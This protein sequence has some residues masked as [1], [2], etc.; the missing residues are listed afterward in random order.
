M[1]KK[2]ISSESSDYSDDEET[3]PTT[4]GQDIE[5]GR[6]RKSSD[7][8]E[9]KELVPLKKTKVTTVTSD[10]DETDGLTVDVLEI[11]SLLVK[12]INL[13]DDPQECLN[14]FY[15]YVLTLKKNIKL[16]VYKL[17]SR[18]KG[19]WEKSPQTTS[20]ISCVSNI[21][22][23]IGHTLCSSKTNT[24]N[25]LKTLQIA[26]DFFANKIKETDSSS[27]SL[28]NQKQTQSTS[29][30]SIPA[31]DEMDGVDV[32]SEHTSL[33][34]LGSQNIQQSL[35]QSM[36]KAEE[37]YSSISVQKDNAIISS[38]WI[39]EEQPFYMIV[40]FYSTNTIKHINRSQWW[41]HKKREMKL[42]VNPDSS[43]SPL[44]QAVRNLIVTS[45]QHLD[46]LVKTGQQVTKRSILLKNL[47]V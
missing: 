10:N 36:N 17:Y 6:K 41:R 31:T 37:I 46:R 26:L 9:P 3:R 33:I 21:E 7:T 1:S 23:W 12:I 8:E 22:N 18:L 44:N 32:T 28:K 15:G 29:M 34:E 43:H 19:E 30:S 45:Q 39:E 13:F 27:S 20:L 11:V 35:T 42:F 40:Q 38:S 4:P 14:S 24:R 2:D 16:N 25:V 47:Y 5:I